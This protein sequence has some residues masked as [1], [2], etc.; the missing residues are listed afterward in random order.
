MY[1]MMIV[2]YKAEHLCSICERSTAQSDD[3][4]DICLLA[5]AFHG[6]YVVPGGVGLQSHL[7]ADD[8]AFERSL[9]IA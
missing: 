5:F 8:T 3:D 2:L 9:K 1:E 6:K 7:H 4:I